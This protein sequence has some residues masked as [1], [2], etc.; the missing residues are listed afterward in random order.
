MG[1]HVFAAVKNKSSLNVTAVRDCLFDAIVPRVSP[2]VVIV[3]VSRSRVC[4]RLDSTM[5]R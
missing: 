1:D 5:A 3:R 4:V 2:M